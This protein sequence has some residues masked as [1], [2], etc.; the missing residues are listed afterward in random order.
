MTIEQFLD[1]AAA[2][3]RSLIVVNRSAPAPIQQ[4]LE[5]T[6]TG[7][8]VSVDQ[9]EIPNTDS[10][11]VLLV[12]PTDTDTEIIASSP[13]SALE[14]TILQVNSDLYK[15]GTAGF[16]QHELPAVLAQLDDIPFQLRD[17]PAA[18][19]EKLLLIAISRYIERRAWQAD[20]GT[21]R[22][23]FQHLS[24]IADER[25]TRTVYE[26]LADSGVQTHVYGVPDWRPPSDSDL[27]MHGGHTTDFRK[28]WF[29]VYTPPTMTETNTNTNTSQSDA[30]PAALLAIEVASGE[31]EGFWTFRQSLIT[32]ITDY[33]TANL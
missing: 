14:E 22:S 25:G 4:L 12:E 30:S 7:Q 31:W 5:E 29:V 27:I 23:S 8:P 24:R 16:E 2:P 13:L 17:Y 33:I 26:T 32:E 20:T 6:F 19:K 18:D 15:T 10:D 11:L 9:Q 3:S 1:A 28:A 21:L